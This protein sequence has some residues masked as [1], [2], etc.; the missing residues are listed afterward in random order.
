MSFTLS[1]S[2]LGLLFLLSLL[3]WEGPCYFLSLNELVVFIASGDTSFDAPGIY[4]WAQA[5]PTEYSEKKE[6]EASC[7]VNKLQCQS[8]QSLSLK[9]PGSL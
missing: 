2:L 3:C 8:T 9:P 4:P 6:S 7:L 5:P 1:C